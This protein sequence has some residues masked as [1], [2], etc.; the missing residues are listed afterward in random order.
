MLL[1]SFSSLVIVLGYFVLDIIYT[2]TCRGT[3]VFMNTFALLQNLCTRAHNETHLRHDSACD[4]QKRMQHPC[5]IDKH[6]VDHRV[7]RK[8]SKCIRYSRS[9]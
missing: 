3:L 1:L 7:T 6:L 5:L 8:Q 9:T 2:Y 4:Q